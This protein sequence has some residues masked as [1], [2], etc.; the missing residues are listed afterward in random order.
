MGQS[1]SPASH[2]RP[3][4]ADDFRLA[5][6]LGQTDVC[7]PG[8][9]ATPAG[10]RLG[11]VASACECRSRCNYHRLRLAARILDRRLVRHSP[12]TVTLMTTQAAMRAIP[13]SSDSRYRVSGADGYP[14]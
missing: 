7:W 12:V 9:H 14:L 10:C 13:L 2:F 11:N 4:L 3:T 5:G 8:Q 6:L 1:L